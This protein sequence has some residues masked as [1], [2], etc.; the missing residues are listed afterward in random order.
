MAAAAAQVKAY[1]TGL[2]GLQRQVDEAQQKQ[3][4]LTQVS[5]SSVSKLAEIYRQQEV[6][7]NQYQETFE[8]YR[9]VFEGL[10]SELARVLDTIVGQLQTYNRAVERNF[11]AIVTSANDVMPRMAGV[12]KQSAEE[13]REHIDELSDALSKGV[14]A[15]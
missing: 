13:L 5:A 14:A 2:A 7:L 6:L 11:D 15:P 10:D 9:G 1:T 3:A 12:L 8:R 4:Q